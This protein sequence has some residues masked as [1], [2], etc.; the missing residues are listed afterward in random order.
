M[1][2]YLSSNPLPPVLEVTP[3]PPFRSSEAARALLAKLTQEGDVEQ[4]KLDL[5][6][7]E[8]LDGIVNLLRHSIQGIVGLLL[9][10]VLVD[11]CQ[12][13]AVEYPRP[14]SRDR[15]DGAG[16]SHGSFHLSTLSLSGA[17][18]WPDWWVA[19]L[20]AVRGA[21]ALERECRGRVGI[22]V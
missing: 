20:V 8:R 2:E 15:G 10:G 11:G 5:Q 7:L 17:L 9:L 12:Y 18:V 4:G 1:S 14:S 16:R 13:A 3:A 6:W 22:L 19:G 21:D